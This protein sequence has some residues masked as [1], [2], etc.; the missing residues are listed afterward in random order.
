M[1]IAEKQIGM[2]LLLMC[3]LIDGKRL[4]RAISCGKTT[5]CCLTHTPKAH[6]QK[7]ASRT[8]C[9]PEFNYL[10]LLIALEWSNTH[11]TQLC[12]AWRVFM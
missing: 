6:S 9:D 10:S 3:D 2:R 12:L 11:Y 8:A 5:H 4:L 7:A 1:H